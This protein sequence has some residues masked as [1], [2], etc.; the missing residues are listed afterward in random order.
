[1]CLCVF[2]HAV[3]MGIGA[4]ICGKLFI[5]SVGVWIAAFSSLVFQGQSVLVYLNARFWKSRKGWQL[6]SGGEDTGKLSSE[7]RLQNGL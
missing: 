6:V 4:L 1:V 3:V 5:S 7:R 2:V